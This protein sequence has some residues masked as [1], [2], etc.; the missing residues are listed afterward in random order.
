MAAL[1]HMVCACCAAM[2]TVFWVGMCLQDEPDPLDAFMAGNA[3]AVAAP[4]VKQEQQQQ[5]DVAMTDADAPDTG[6][7]EVKAEPAAAAAAVED[8]EV[9]PLDAF[10]AAEVGMQ[11]KSRGSA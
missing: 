1:A 4:A 7:A 11:C 5:A 8:D 10:M 2:I 3:A 9:D 6:H